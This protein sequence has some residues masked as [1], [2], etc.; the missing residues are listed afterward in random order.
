MQRLAWFRRLFLDLDYVLILNLSW[1]PWIRICFPFGFHDLYFS[2]LLLLLS[3]EKRF[4]RWFI[5][6]VRV[7]FKGQA[8]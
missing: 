1:N 2:W 6:S 3:I 4:D 5:I 7:I 8:D